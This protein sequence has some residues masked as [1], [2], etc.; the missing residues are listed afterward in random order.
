M[1]IAEAMTRQERIDKIA[2]LVHEIRTAM[3]VTLDE[4]G[5]PRSRPN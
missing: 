4:H 5:R 2:D 1:T 3:L